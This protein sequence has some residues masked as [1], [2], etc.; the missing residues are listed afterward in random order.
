MTVT[1]CHELSDCMQ[2]CNMLVCKE[3]QCSQD[4]SLIYYLNKGFARVLV[5]AKILR[6]DAIK[7]LVQLWAQS[8]DMSTN[9][10]L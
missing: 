2:T 7:S 3:Q 4:A 9:F 1:L 10:W 6:K 8:Y 5:L